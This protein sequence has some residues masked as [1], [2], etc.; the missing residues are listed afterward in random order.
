MEQKA[1]SM[2]TLGNPMNAVANISYEI[3]MFKT[4]NVSHLEK[5]R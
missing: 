5:E 4:S 2:C 3:S 1:K